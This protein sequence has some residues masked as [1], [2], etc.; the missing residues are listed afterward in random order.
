VPFKAVIDADTQIKNGVVRLIAV[1]HQYITAMPEYSSLSFEE[2]R[3]QY[4][5]YNSSEQTGYFIYMVLSV[6][7]LEWYSVYVTSLSLHPAI[8]YG[9]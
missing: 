9:F 2:L 3:L 7:Y 6:L 4:D 5:K 1:Q 8:L